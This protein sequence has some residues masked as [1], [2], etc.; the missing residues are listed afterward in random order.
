MRVNRSLANLSI[1][2]ASTSS[3]ETLLR[4]LAEHAATNCK[5]FYPAPPVRKV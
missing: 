3:I 2:A 4:V 1:A 5:F